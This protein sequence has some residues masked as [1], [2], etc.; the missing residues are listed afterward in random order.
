MIT[1]KEI[2]NKRYDKTV[3][4]SPIGFDYFL[5]YQEENTNQKE[6]VLKASYQVLDVDQ[7]MWQMVIVSN[8]SPIRTNTVY[9][10]EYQMPMHNMAIELVAATG[11]NWF[12]QDMVEEIQEKQKIQFLLSDRLR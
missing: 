1:F 3:S 8:K 12:M 2:V 4:N 11:L 7:D 6:I 5:E 9:T 10:I